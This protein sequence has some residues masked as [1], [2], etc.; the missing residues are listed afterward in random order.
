MWPWEWLQGKVG[1]GP[2]GRHGV[3]SVGGM[4][5]RCVAAGLLKGAW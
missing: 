3:T 5:V 4:H 2:C 1:Q